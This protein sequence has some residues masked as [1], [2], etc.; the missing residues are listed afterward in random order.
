[1]MRSRL[2]DGLLGHRQARIAQDDVGVGL[3]VGEESEVARFA[4]NT[5]DDG[6]DLEKAPRFA[7][8]HEWQASEPEPRPMMP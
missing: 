1:M 7:L 5:D 6:I 8:L 2:L 3:A 4:R